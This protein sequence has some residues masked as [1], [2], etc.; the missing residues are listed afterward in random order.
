MSPTVISFFV[1]WSIISLSFPY[2]CIPIYCHENSRDTCGS[3]NSHVMTFRCSQCL[4]QESRRSY[5]GLTGLSGDSDWGHCAPNMPGASLE[6]GRV[7]GSHQ[8]GKI[9]PHVTSSGEAPLTLCLVS[10]ESRELHEV[11]VLIR[12]HGSPQAVPQH[13]NTLYPASPSSS[14]SVALSSPANRA[15]VSSWCLP[16]FPTLGPAA[17]DV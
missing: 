8:E 17:V 5:L 12:P 10:H 3:P 2:P 4:E 9:Y 13:L 1:Y 11:V 15:A 16:L 7:K 14:S 6:Q